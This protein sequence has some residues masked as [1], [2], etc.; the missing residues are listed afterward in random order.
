M[1]NP[2]SLL[3]PEQEQA[4]LD[5]LEQLLKNPWFRH[6]QTQWLNSYDNTVLMVFNMSIPN[7]AAE[8]AREQSIGEARAYQLCSESPIIKYNELIAQRN[9]KE[10]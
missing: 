1:D 8:V 6:F 2:N 4:L 10:V 3:L 7:K 5:Q 9:N